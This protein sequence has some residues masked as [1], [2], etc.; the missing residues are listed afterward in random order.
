MLFVVLALAVL[1][2]V[3]LPLDPVL[4]AFGSATR[5]DGAQVLARP[6]FWAL[7]GAFTIASFA[8]ACVLRRA[9][10][11]AILGACVLTA[12][13][14]LA[15]WA[16][17]ERLHD[18][19]FVFL[20][21]WSPAALGF[22]ACAAFLL[23]SLSAFSVRGADRTGLR[24]GSAL[25]VA[26][27][28]VLAPTLLAS[29]RAASTGIHI[30]L[31]DPAAHISEVIP[32]P[33]GR[34]LAV[35]VG[36]DWHLSSDWL[37]ITG[38]DSPARRF[39]GAVWIL[40]LSRETWRDLPGGYSAVSRE[41]YCGF[42]LGPWDSRGRL[43]I[44]TAEGALG[45][46][47]QKAQLIDPVS[48]AAPFSIDLNTDSLDRLRAEAGFESWYALVEASTETR[49][50]LRWSATG[51]EMQLF[52]REAFAASPE[53][54]IV[55]FQRAGELVRH[56][57]A[58]ECEIVLRTL[59]YELQ[60][61][62]GFR[63]SPDGRHLALRGSGGYTIIDASDG[64]TVAEL[65]Q[66]AWFNGWSRVPGRLGL[67]CVSSARCETGWC[68]LDEHGEL[69]PLPTSMPRCAELGP[70]MLLAYDGQRIERVS[71]DGRQH[72]V[73]YEARP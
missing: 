19:L 64:H 69:H 6:T 57:M 14:L 43:A 39:M 52:G 62:N 50:V 65:P 44:Y 48:L 12:L 22:L 60:R 54:G 24:R 55:F 28:L 42:E 21:Y 41:Y 49:K 29:V 63:V 33:N 68:V 45:S 10:P 56:D 13:P 27:V 38:T 5:L 34:F 47:I 51:L 7:A 36:K 32:S 1:V 3:L 61:G 8:F 73:L 15:G 58:T 71:I 67:V 9:L 26:V 4:T 18:R 31:H 25:L 17:S 11:A 46:G 59:P 2:L 16:E 66:G 70:D 20:T 53:P 40:D 37:A 35:Q 72:E 30:A 23:G